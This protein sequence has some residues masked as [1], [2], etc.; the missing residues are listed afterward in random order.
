MR[1]G[2][3]EKGVLLGVVGRSE[4]IYSRKIH[5]PEN[6]FSCGISVALISPK[7]D[8]AT[9]KADVGQARRQAL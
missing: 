6:I 7:M 8:S 2:A 5:N 9:S 1:G 4:I 3:H